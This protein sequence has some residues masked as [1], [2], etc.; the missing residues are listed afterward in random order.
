[1]GGDSAD[2]SEKKRMDLNRIRMAARLLRI[3][4][5]TRDFKDR[6]PSISR[7]LPNLGRW[8]FGSVSSRC[9]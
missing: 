4:I 1:M 7:C 3:H 6:F 5:G 9:A 8:N 2:D